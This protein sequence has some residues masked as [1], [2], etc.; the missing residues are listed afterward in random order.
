ML[1]SPLL[2]LLARLGVVAGIYTL[3]RVTF[4]LLNH[5]AFPNV[6]WTAYLG[7]VRFD[8]SALAWLNMPWVLLC[9]IHPTEEGWYG[10]TKKIV[11]HGVNVTGFFF[12]CADMEYFKFTLKRSTAD[13]F[14]IMAGGGDTGSL[15]TVFAKDYWYIVLI[16]LACIAL[17]ELGYRW[18]RRF[19]NEGRLP[20]VRQLV[21]R[22][23]AGG[24]IA[25]LSRGGLQLIPLGVMNAGDYAPPPYFPVVLNT[26]FTIM[27]TMGKPVVE[28]KKYMSEEAADRLWPVTHQYH[29]NDPGSAP[30]PRPNVVVIILESFSAAYSAKL[31]GGPDCMPFLDS[32]M[33]HSLTFTRAYANGRRSIDGVPAITASIPELMDEAFIT[34][35]YAQ[36]PFT[37][38]ANVL[39]AEGYRTSFFH[40]G[41][42]GTMGFDA[43][44]KS[45]GFQR[46][47]GLNE[48][49]DQSDYDGSWGIW[50][51]PFLQFFAQE[52]TKEQQPFLS[53]VFTLS[54]HHPYHLLPEDEQRFAGGTQKIQPS[55][56]YTDDALRQ[57]FAT[58]RKMS[59][60]EHTLFVITADHTADLDRTGQNYS[61]ATDYWV[62]LLYFMPS[63]IQ[64]RPVDRVTQHIDIVPTVLDLMGH[65]KPFFSF[66]CT[67]LRDERLPL[68]VTRTTGSYLAVDG[69]G[70]LRFDGKHTAP[71][72]T[73]MTMV[74]DIRQKE[75]ALKAA[76][77]QFNNRLL[78][79]ELVVK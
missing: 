24:L 10:L 41:R 17:A 55:L 43:F 45:A 47:V 36:T 27:M 64:P 67:A 3:L 72:P 59:W 76:I 40:G 20:L 5:A 11:F 4:V 54:S 74:P 51:R 2:V 21:W 70:V 32:L 6:P 66:G 29:P 30:P 1:R 49:P 35:T 39:A 33:D 60:S 42:N 12:N 65:S 75:A 25:L 58:A 22:G 61:E 53:C 9:I 15:A 34:S 46:Y 23:V 13:L 31:G 44:A 77:Q 52:L 16:F 79:N 68:M 28:E 56:R 7:G 8:L 26:P 48:Y 18:A 69:E 19:A 71:P 73:N 50:D 78:H 14:G 38:I 57:F 63:G 62:P 37:S